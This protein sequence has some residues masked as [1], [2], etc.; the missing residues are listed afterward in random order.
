M[1][2]AILR[3][4]N[5]KANILRSLGSVSNF[6]AEWDT[7]NIDYEDKIEFVKKILWFGTDVIV[8]SPIEIKNEV[9]SQLSRSSNG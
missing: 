5:G 1:L 3:V 4:R 2:P 8:V 7:L 9:I 6:D